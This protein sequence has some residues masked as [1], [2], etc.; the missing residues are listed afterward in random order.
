MLAD[1]PIGVCK[2]TVFSQADRSATDI[3]FGRK[4]TV[5]L[6]LPSAFPSQT[7]T[8]GSAQHSNRFARRGRRAA[9]C[10]VL[11]GSVFAAW[12]PAAAQSGLWTWMGGSSTVPGSNEGQ[13][14]VYGT[15]GTPAAANIPGGRGASAVWIDHSG[16]TWLFGGYG[17]DANGASSYLNDLWKLN[18]TTNEWT[19][20]SGST[21]IGADGGQPACT[22]PWERPP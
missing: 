9:I 19:W 11:A 16:N 10:L 3:I 5:M 21:T 1:A 12:I 8:Q 6:R 13:P 2:E 14:G 15:M 20:M 18:P 17:A 7:S 4:N 22:A